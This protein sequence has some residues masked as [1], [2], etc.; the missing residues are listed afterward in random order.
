MG[1]RN[2]TWRVEMTYFECFAILPK[3]CFLV[4]PFSEERKDKRI[5]T[6]AG[7]VCFFTDRF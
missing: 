3:Y 1:L 2:T 5:H 6:R 7:S 4:F